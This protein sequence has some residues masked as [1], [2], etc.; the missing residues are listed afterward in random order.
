MA[1]P[2]FIYFDLGNVLLHFDHGLACRKI[3]QLTERPED[4]IQ[5]ILFG[6]HSLQWRYEAGTVCC[7]EFCD[8]LRQ[9]TETTV[10][11]SDLLEACSHIF[12]PRIS[13]VPVIANLHASG[14]RLGI[15]SNTCRAHWDYVI[16]GRYRFLQVGF[17]HYVL[18]FE[19][20][21]MKPDRAIYDAAARR[22]D[23]PPDQIFFTDDR[24]ENVAGARA[25]GWQAHHF[26]CAT[27]LIET[28]YRLGV[29][30]NL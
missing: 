1:A 14:H 12:W 22:A 23:V 26:T 17:E 16:Q 15:L 27:D 4:Q 18:S 21:S 2:R 11:D 10:P 29:R 3:G 9:R 30:C 8:E 28:L 24:E 7:E 6:P 25:A 19:E 20:R 13:M 5:Q